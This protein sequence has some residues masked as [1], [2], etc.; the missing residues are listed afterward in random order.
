MKDKKVEQETVPSKTHNYI[1]LTVI[2]VVFVA[3][4]L[5]LCQVYKVGQE[6]KMRIPVI[7][8]ALQEIYQEDLEHYIMDNPTALIYMCTANDDTCRSFE[9][10]FKKLLRKKDYND[11]IIYLNLTDVDQDEFVKKFNEMY[12]YK[13]KLTTRYPAFVLFEDGKIDSVLQGK[14]D[15]PLTITKV[16]QFL[17]LSQIGE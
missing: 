13:I 10:D 2:V 14:E 12:H 15:K 3:F 16:K 6:E 9:R 5:Y 8:G 17:E 4:V 11:S 7:S 1:L